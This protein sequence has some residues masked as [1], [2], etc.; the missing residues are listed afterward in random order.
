[1]DWR[2]VTKRPFL[3]ILGRNA[4]YFLTTELGP[5]TDLSPTECAQSL[6]NDRFYEKQTL[7]LSPGNF[8]L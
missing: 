8:R 6:G 7:R 2:L 1:M 4:L 5:I 3:A